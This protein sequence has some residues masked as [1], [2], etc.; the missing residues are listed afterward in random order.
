MLKTF[1]EDLKMSEEEGSFGVT[2]IERLVGLIVLIMGILTTY[3]TLTSINTLAPFT[4]L[5]ALLSIILI[6]LGLFLILAKT[7]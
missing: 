7:E 1:K 2:F 3:Y 4:G 5:F 6:L